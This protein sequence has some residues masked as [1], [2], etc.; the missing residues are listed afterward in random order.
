M[1]RKIT[2]NSKEEMEK[3]L[4]AFGEE[5]IKKRYEILENLDNA[6]SI[7]IK[8]EIKPGEVM[9]YEVS[10]VEVLTIEDVVKG[11]EESKHSD[12]DKN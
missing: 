1:K 10:R 9:S 12:R 11:K 5:I 8:M 4:K 3:G 6:M 2:T 7:T